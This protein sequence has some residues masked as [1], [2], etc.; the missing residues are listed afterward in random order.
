MTFI[1][2]ETNCGKVLADAAPAP[3]AEVIAVE[4]IPAED[5]DRYDSIT[6]FVADVAACRVCG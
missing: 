4:F 2:T 6:Y 1:T 5:S 3:D